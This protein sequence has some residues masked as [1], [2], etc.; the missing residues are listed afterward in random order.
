MNG[1]AKRVAL[2]GRRLPVHLQPLPDAQRA[3]WLARLALVHGAPLYSFCRQLWPQHARWN[4][5]IDRMFDVPM[6]T[7]WAERTA[8]PYERV[9]ETTLGAFA[10]KRIERFSTAAAPRWLLPP[11]LL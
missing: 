11:G 4:R 2:S 6:R 10:G 7:V 5:D 1:R 3:S 8:T 9:L